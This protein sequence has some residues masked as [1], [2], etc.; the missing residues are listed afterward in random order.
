[1]ANVI[2]QTDEVERINGSLKFPN[3][4][5]QTDERLIKIFERMR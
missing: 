3:G 4:W 1:M 2:F 5:G